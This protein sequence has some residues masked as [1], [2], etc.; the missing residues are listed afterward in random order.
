MGPC[1][2]TISYGKLPANATL[3]AAAA[4]SALLVGTSERWQHAKKGKRVT[5][6]A[7]P[8]RPHST[9]VP[10]D[11]MMR[12]SRAGLDFAYPFLECAATAQKPH[13]SP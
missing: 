3:A 12:C 2:A 7:R 8:H 4:H 9:C 6:L 10:D 5:N 11:S 13:R 1:R